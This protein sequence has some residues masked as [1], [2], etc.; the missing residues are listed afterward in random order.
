M[1]TDIGSLRQK[2]R[3][4]ANKNVHWSEKL[5]VRNLTHSD[6]TRK[7][8]N[9]QCQKDQTFS[10]HTLSGGNFSAHKMYFLIVFYNNYLFLIIAVNIKGKT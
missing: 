3:S 6:H 10:K 1:H 5:I 9:N 2:I 4:L 7:V 8:K